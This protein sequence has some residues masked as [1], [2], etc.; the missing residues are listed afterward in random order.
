MLRFN[1]FMEETQHG[2]KKSRLWTERKLYSL[3]FPK[4]YCIVTEQLTSFKDDAVVGYFVSSLQAG[5]VPTVSSELVLAFVDGNL[6]SLNC[7]SRHVRVPH[8]HLQLAPRQTWQ[9]ETHR[10][11]IQDRVDVGE[12]QAQDFIGVYPAWSTQDQLLTRHKFNQYILCC[13]PK[14]TSRVSVGPWVPQQSVPVIPKRHPDLMVHRLKPH[15]IVGCCFWD[16]FTYDHAK[17]S[18]IKKLVTTLYTEVEISTNTKVWSN[19]ILHANIS[20]D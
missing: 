1:C 6:D 9:C 20:A 18:P 19:S 5:A 14:S 8:A 17:L 7:W 11:G 13:S 4:W 3:P 12:L 2:S 16:G 10:V 15:N